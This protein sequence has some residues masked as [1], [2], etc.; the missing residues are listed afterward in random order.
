M[1]SSPEGEGFA[2]PLWGTL[3]IIFRHTIRNIG[4]RPRSPFSFDYASMMLKDGVTG[5]AQGRAGSL[6]YTRLGWHATVA[7]GPGSQ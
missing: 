1:K 2:D 7:T 4:L 3:T 5:T 6:V